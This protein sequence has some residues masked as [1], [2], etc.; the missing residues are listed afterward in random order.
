ML[1][2]NLTIVSMSGSHKTDIATCDFLPYIL[3]FDQ[4][5]VFLQDYCV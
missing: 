2:G 4:Y 1:D 3:P 5:I